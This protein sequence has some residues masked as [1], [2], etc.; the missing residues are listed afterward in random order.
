[1]CIAATLDVG[2]NLPFAAG[3]DDHTGL[4]ELGL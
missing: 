2:A 4:G 3:P 1:M